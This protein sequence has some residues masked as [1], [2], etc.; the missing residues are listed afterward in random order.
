M[1]EIAATFV[2]TTF[3]ASIAAYNTAISR[4]YNIPEVDLTTV[5]NSLSELKLSEAA[6][7][8]VTNGIHPEVK[9]S[10]PKMTCPYQIT[11]GDRKGLPCGKNCTKG[12]AFCSSH[13]NSKTGAVPPPVAGVPAPVVAAAPAA[14]AAPV[15]AAATMCI[16]SITRGDRKGQPCGKK[17]ASGNPHYCSSHKATG[18][19]PAPVPIVHAP[20]ALPIYATAPALALP[21][22]VPV[23][24]PVP[25]VSAIPAPAE[26]EDQEVDNSIF[27]E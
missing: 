26:A 19:G 6:P 24:A 18:G 7:M 13:K 11:R 5:W 21:N 10:S 3:M 12:S 14:V 27:D 1:T 23:T 17:T 20:A 2:P 16:F 22:G 8:V 4:K 9:T 15:A 25:L